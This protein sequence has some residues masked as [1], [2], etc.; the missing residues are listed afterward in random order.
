MPAHK[1]KPLR[2]DGIITGFGRKHDDW[3]R[4]DPVTDRYRVFLHGSEVQMIHNGAQVALGEN[5]AVDGV[6]A[7][8]QD[9][10]DHDVDSVFDLSGFVGTL[11]EIEKQVFHDWL[12][13]CSAEVSSGGDHV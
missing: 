6:R 5:E 13:F 8:V 10:L 2:E 4:P 11:G 1:Q 3:Q 12:T 9:L 7:K